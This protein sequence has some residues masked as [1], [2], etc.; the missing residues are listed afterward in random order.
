M[1]Q[2][3]PSKSLLTKKQID[4]VNFCSVPRTKHKVTISVQIICSSRKFKEFISNLDDS[5]RVI[6]AKA[7]YDYAIREFAYE[8]AR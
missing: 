2:D 5:N 7:I 6:F 3:A 1:H 4:I 8:F